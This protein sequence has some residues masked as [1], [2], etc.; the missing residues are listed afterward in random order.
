VRAQL[1]RDGRGTGTKQRTGI[2]QGWAREKGVSK[3]GRGEGRQGWARKP[4]VYY[5]DG[6]QFNKEYRTGMGE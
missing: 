5:G 2:G 3:G 6:Q 4:E 1:D